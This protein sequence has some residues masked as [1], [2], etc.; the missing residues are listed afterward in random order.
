MFAE[1]FFKIDNGYGNCTEVT[2]ANPSVEGSFSFNIP[3][4]QIPAG[5][6]TLFI[7]VPGKLLPGW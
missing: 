3:S 6:D 5:A 2:L 7:R 1:Y 4:S